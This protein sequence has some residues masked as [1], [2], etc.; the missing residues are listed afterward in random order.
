M[1]RTAE[2]T[3]VPAIMH[4]EVLS[5]R[6]MEVVSVSMIVTRSTYTVPGVCTTIGHIEVR[7]SEVEVVA[8]WVT[9]IDAEVPVAS[10]PVEGA[11]EIGGCDKGVPLPVEQDIAQI[12]VTTLPI[13]SEHIVA[14]CHT[15]QVVEVD[16]ISCLVLLISQIQLIS[17]LISEEEG[18]VAGLLVA[19]CLY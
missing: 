14:S 7:T 15:H 18:L 8:I 19:H 17:H 10:V 11:I 13:G 6:G 2:V 16:L 1:A 4:A 3:T 12:E 5:V 9:G